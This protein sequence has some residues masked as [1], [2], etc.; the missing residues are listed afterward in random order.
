MLIELVIQS[1]TDWSRPLSVTS[2][3]VHPLTVTN[4]VMEMR[5]DKNPNAQLLARLDQTGSADGL[6]SVLSPGNY[7]LSLSAAKT[8][9]MPWG[10]GF[11]DIFGDVAGKR[12]LVESGV[13][14]V[15]PRAT[16]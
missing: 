9:T 4:L 3:G 2:D 15:R 6:I 16:T 10:R 13:V 12:V 8:S 14:M 1:G 11:W 5:R 7:T